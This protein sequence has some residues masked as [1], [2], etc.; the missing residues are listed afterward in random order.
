MDDPSDGERTA[1]AVVGGR[2]KGVR[3]PP[4]VQAQGH[5]LP[6]HFLAVAQHDLDPGV[7]I[8]APLD[9][10]ASL[11]AEDFHGERLALGRVVVLV[12][13]EGLVLALLHAGEPR[14]VALHGG[15]VRR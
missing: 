10:V 3:E 15:V 5:Q 11:L 9:T 8:L 4:G 12:L 1:A 7:A 13:G 2:V 14:E 6:R